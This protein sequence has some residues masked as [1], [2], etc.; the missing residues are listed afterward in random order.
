MIVDLRSDTVT[1]PTPAMRKAM[2]EA[3]VGDDVFGEDPTVNRLQERV[4]ELLGQES[5]LFV[6]TGTMSNEIAIKVWTKP[7]DAVLMDEECHILHYEL[8]GPAV[9]AGVQMEQV[10]THRG[11]MNV[12]EVRKRIRIEDD[13]CPGTALLCVEN[14]H[15]R[16]G[17]TIL[18]IEN[19]KELSEC[20]RAHGLRL[21][22]DGAR[23]MNAAVAMRKPATTWTQYV[24]SVTICLSKGLGCP[25]GS[26]LAGSQEFI[27][28]AHRVRKLFGGGMRQVGVLAA[29]GLVAIETMIDRMAEDHQRAQ[30]LAVAIANMPQYGID[31]EAV[32]TN[33]LY[34]HTK[35]PA[36]EVE[37][38]L[39]AHG[40]L[41]LGIDSHRLR[42][43]TH[44]EIN[45][46]GIEHA[47]AALSKVG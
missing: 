5:A 10:P 45:D 46:A 2:A 13:H 28:Q 9:L 3:E 4:A 38:A 40:V 35:P 31:L 20:A 6:P 18:P 1:K 37:Q 12:E 16:C 21:H 27:H 24:D 43:I 23:L 33:I 42:M 47:I 39:K 32:Q 26:V 7:G 41:T 30:K 36:L 22:M 34:V 29:A 17:G 15:N 11:V 44:Y 8:A 14:T 25:V 19:L